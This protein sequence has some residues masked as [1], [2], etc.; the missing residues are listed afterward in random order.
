MRA[1]LGTIVRSTSTIPYNTL[2][3]FYTV[4]FNTFFTHIPFPTVYS[5]AAEYR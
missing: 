4:E 5:P 1:C 3:E 2:Q